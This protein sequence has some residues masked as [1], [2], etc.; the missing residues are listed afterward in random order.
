MHQITCYLDFASPYAHL[1]FG[2]LPQLLEGLSYAVEYRPV[3]LGAL[4][5]QHG[6]PGPAGIA[7]K[8][9]W[10]YRQ[11]QWLGHAHGIALQMP[12]QHP[13]N[14]LPLLRLALAASEDGSLSRHVAGTV[15]SHVWQGGADANDAQRLAALAAA[16]P[17]RHD[18]AGPEVKA[19]LRAN[20]DA[21]LAR[22]VF[23]VPSF[24]VAGRLFWGFD[25]MPMLR[26]CLDGDAWFDGPAWEAAAA[27]PNGLKPG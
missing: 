22:G 21:A 18:P 12:A 24:E 17:L 9:A 14:P 3:L 20:T 27:Q 2:R 1:A 11:V 8:R 4:L 7:P 19:L 5:L 16:L 26:A 25:G 13:F 6:N 23:G 15:L 10:T